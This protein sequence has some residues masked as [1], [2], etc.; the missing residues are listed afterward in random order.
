MCLSAPAENISAML[1][2][3]HPEWREYL[4][5][6]CAPTFHALTD[7]RK[8]YVWLVATGEEQFFDLDS[9]PQELHNLAGQ[10]SWQS[11]LSAWRQRLIAE[12]ENRPEGFTDGE[13]L[14]AGRPYGA[15]LP[16]AGK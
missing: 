9:D 14:I 4:H 5:L 11:T 12:L 13:R 1:R 10:E 15:T 8:K 6:E 7:G 3:E 2:G 16:D